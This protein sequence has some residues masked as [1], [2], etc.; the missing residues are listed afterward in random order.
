MAKTEIQTTANHS[1]SPIELALVSGD[2]SQMAP[3]QRLSYYK[4]ICE[5]VGLNPLTRPFE[6]ITL[7]GKL[8]LYARKDATDQLRK[9]NSISISEPTIRFEDDWI[10]VTVTARTPDGRSDSDIGAVKKTDMNGNFGNALMKAV[11]KSKRRVTLAICGLG[12]LDET[13]VETIPDA[14]PYVEQSQPDRPAT[15]GQLVSSALSDVE[16]QMREGVEKLLV[17]VGMKPDSTLKKFDE[18]PDKRENGWIA[19]MKA[20]LKKLIEDPRWAYTDEGT[21]Q[22]LEKFGITDIDTA[23]RGQLEQLFTDMTNNGVLTRFS[24]NP[25][26]DH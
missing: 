9:V 1:L 18:H 17:L 22:L 3:D 5:S 10:L 12:M 19:V 6:Y 7:N 23:G 24:K 15:K 8:T 26:E 20:V 2:L 11:T 14:K 16:K 4:Q 25:E 21:Q 13:E